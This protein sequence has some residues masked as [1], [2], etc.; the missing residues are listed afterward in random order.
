M[1]KPKDLIP[2][3]AEIS[4]VNDLGTSTWYE[5]VYHIGTWHSYGQSKTFKDGETVLRWK[6]CEGLLN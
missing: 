3:L 1:E 6:Y 5:V 2:V 4:H